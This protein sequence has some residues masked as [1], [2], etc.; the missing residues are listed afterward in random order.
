MQYGLQ[1]KCLNIFTGLIF[2]DVFKETGTWT[3]VLAA[4]ALYL[5]CFTALHTTSICGSW[6]RSVI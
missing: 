4:S 1:G 3:S 5:F 6:I 2:K